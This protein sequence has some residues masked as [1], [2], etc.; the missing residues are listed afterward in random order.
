MN[1]STP[2]RSNTQFWNEGTVPWL[3]S[4]ELNQFHINKASEKI[5]ELALNKSSLSLISPGA[6]L[7]G[8]VGQGKTRGMTARLDIGAAINQNVAAITPLFGRVCSDFLHYMLQFLY[9]PIRELGRGGQQAAL[10]CEIVKTIR[11]PLPSTDE[12]EKIAAFLR[13]TLTLLDQLGSMAN[14]QIDLLSE[15]RSALISAAVT[16]KIDVRNW[17]PPADESAFDEEIRQAGTEATA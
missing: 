13:E 5:T 10:N 14:Q 16:G 17:H 1:G 4:S 8:L 12:Q 2:D 6:I 9:V 11:F 15:R 3:S 7:I